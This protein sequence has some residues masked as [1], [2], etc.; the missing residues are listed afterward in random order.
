MADYCCHRSAKKSH[1]K[2]KDRKCRFS[3]KENWSYRAYDGKNNNLRNYLWGCAGQNL[4]RLCP[5]DYA[6]GKNSMATRGESN[7]NPRAI[8]NALCRTI[9]S[10][11]NS[12]HLTDCFWLWGQFLDHEL[13]ISHTGSE[14]ANIVAPSDDPV[15]PNATI[16]F[17]RSKYDPETGTD[18]PRQQINAISSFIDGTNVYGTYGDRI[19]ALRKLDGSGELMTEIFNGHELLPL[20]TKGFENATLLGTDP[21]TYFLAGDIRSNENILLTSMHTLFVLEHNRLARE[22]AHRHP[23]WVGN[24]EKIFSEAR[25]MVIAFMQKIT[26]ENFIPLLLGS[27]ALPYYQGYDSKTHPDIAN[28]FSTC[29][30]RLGHSM[31]S[32]TLLSVN[33]QNES[34][35]VNLTTSFFNPQYLKQNG[36]ENLLRGSTQNIMKEVDSTIVEGLRNNLFGPPNPDT[37]MMLDLAALN[38]QRGR[39][40]GLPD[41]NSLRH[42]YGLCKV[43]SFSEITRNQRLQAQLSSIYE[44]VDDIDPW[45]GG[46][47]EDHIL[48]AQVG[49]LFFQILS[50]QFRRL[51]D[52]DRFYYEN[53]P[54]LSERQK[55]IIR[56]T[57]LS[58]IIMR[59][60]SITG[61]QRNVFKR[62]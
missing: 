46:L 33:N 23:K 39:D 61:L 38:I 58:D 2:F 8:S 29:A 22:I 16:P 1:G 56:N 6:D 60:T 27:K 36:I 49:P 12:C 52:G 18:N 26:F 59:N 14:E 48:K 31:V 50:D 28:E 24:D 11:K 21:S 44:T 19:S 32:E 10:S 42:A 57:T 7:P 53:D 35:K 34:E 5:T 43:K 30:Y 40:H 3:L 41:Y 45:I 51:R 9:I 4:Y 54:T 55:N 25:K 13:G 20:N 47:C 37:K 17:N 15:L 62:L